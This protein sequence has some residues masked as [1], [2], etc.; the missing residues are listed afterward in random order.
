M[1]INGHNSIEVSLFMNASWSDLNVGLYGAPLEAWSVT[2]RVCLPCT[3]HRV[4]ER[5]KPAYTPAWSVA[6]STWDRRG[7]AGDGCNACWQA[8]SYLL[9]AHIGLPMQRPEL[10]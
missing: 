4:L 5:T 9:N 2:S 1:A 10:C 6:R 3:R 7:C 8:K